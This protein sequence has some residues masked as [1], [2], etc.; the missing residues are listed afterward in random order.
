MTGALAAIR[1]RDPW[2]RALL[3]HS[4]SVN[5][6]F[7][8]VVTSLLPQSTGMRDLGSNGR[9]TCCL[10]E[11]YVSIEFVLSQPCDAFAADTG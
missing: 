4:Y 2:T 11:R 8:E 6:T 10:N 3:A 7:D 1:N 5:E 9:N